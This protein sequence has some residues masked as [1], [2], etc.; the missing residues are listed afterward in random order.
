MPNI[1]YLLLSGRCNS[2]VCAHD[3]RDGE[4]ISCVASTIKSSHLSAHFCKFCDHWEK[5]PDTYIHLLQRAIQDIK[6]AQEK[7]SQLKEKA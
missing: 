6:D 3:K 1:E 7:F 4:E 2:P 5:T